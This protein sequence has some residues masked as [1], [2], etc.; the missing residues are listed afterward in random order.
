MKR[1]LTLLAVPLLTLACSQHG[2]SASNT[3]SSTQPSAAAREAEFLT[4][5]RQL[6]S[7]SQFARAGEAYFSHDM[8]WVVFQAAPKGEENYQMYLAKLDWTTG[9]ALKDLV[10]ISPPNS[11]NTCGWFSEDGHTLIFASTAGKDDPEEARAGYQRTG[12]RYRWAFSKGMEIYRVTDWQAKVQ[13]AIETGNRHRPPSKEEFIVPIDAAANSEGKQRSLEVA[14][15]F[16]I[17]E[18]RLTNNDFYDAECVLTKGG[19]WV[20]FC[21]TRPG[22][23][24]WGGQQVTPPDPIN[25]PAKNL[26]AMSLSNPDQVVQLTTS[27][28]YSGGPFV[29]PDGKQLIYRCDRVGN[30]LLQIYVADLVYDARGYNIKGLANERK[31]TDDA[32]VNWGPYWLPDNRHILYASSKI[33]H[34]NYEIFLRDIDAPATSDATRITFDPGPDVLPVISPDGKWM[35]W[36][37]RRGADQTTQVYIARFAMKSHQ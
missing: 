5:I 35:M 30:D 9:P 33:S 27:P 16:A 29:S 34:G 3:W 24:A 31:V 20:I 21:S 15:N 26:W 8:K 14:I 23:V 13:R 1:S 18:N 25:N 17:P 22:Q 4:D 7:G 36:A 32:N 11:R 19:H 37:S 6:T 12:S 10:R 2:P 28:G